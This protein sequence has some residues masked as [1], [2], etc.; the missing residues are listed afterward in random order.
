MYALH[1][2]PTVEIL[3]NPTK[4]N[5]KPQNNSGRALTIALRTAQGVYIMRGVYRMRLGS[6]PM[7]SGPVLIDFSI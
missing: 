6:V 1:S 3:E 4:I 2:C 5:G 7:V